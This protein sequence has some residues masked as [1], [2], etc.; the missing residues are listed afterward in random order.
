VLNDA[1]ARTTTGAASAFD[2]VDGVIVTA[3]DRSGRGHDPSQMLHQPARGARNIRWQVAGLGVHEV[4]QV[5]DPGH[6]LPPA[7][8]LSTRVIAFVFSYPV[9]SAQRQ[10][11]AAAAHDSRGRR[12]LQAD[13]GRR[14]CAVS[15][16]LNSHV[17]SALAAIN[18]ESIADAP[19]VE[20][21]GF[22]TASYS[23]T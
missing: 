6:A 12:R 23:F 17:G 2:L 7:I 18:T 22:A 11:S 14:R 16:G 13:V 15:T 4:T 8:R 21:Q 10:A 5:G 3:P 1:G 19:N 9:L 20:R